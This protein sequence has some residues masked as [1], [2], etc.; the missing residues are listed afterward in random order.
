M[1][2]GQEGLLCFSWEA[3]GD[4]ITTYGL[5]RRGRKSLVGR[6]GVGGFFLNMC[7]KYTY[8]FGGG[9]N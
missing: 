3:G 5:R 6:E 4:L 8:V 1:G 7:K 9:G 2:I